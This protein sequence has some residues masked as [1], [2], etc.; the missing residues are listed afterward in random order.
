[1]K[2]VKYFFAATVTCVAFVIH[3]QAPASAPVPSTTAAVAPEVIVT[4]E[5]MAA[6]KELLAAMNFKQMMSQ[7]AGAMAKSMPQ[8]MDQMLASNT[9]LSE[10][11]KA[12]ARKLNAKSAESAM[13]ALSD[14]Y[15]DPQVVQGMEDIM[16]SKYVKNFTIG[17]IN[18]ITAFYV[19][20][21]GKKTL[22]LTPRLMQEM[23]P[24]IMSLIAPRMNA[25]IAKIA[26]EVAEEAKKNSKANKPGAPTKK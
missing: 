1:M 15:N 13:K 26:D 10:S 17:E 20:P 4:A 9:K 6:V 11:E 14:I 23:M 22:N 8:A 7:M 3:A 21:A 18:A 5:Q 25:V 2:F 19:S 24:E 16:A 12:E